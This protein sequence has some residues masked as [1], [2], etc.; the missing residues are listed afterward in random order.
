MEVGHVENS[1]KLYL[2][3]VEVA[4]GEFRQVI[5]GLR[6]YVPEA[7]PGSRGTGHGARGPALALETT[8]IMPAT[9]QGGTQLKTRGFKMRGMTWQA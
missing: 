1:D 3:K 5:T 9:S 7:G 8:V 4:P 2:C 6:K